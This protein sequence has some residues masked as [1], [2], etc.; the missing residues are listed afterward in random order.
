MDGQTFEEIE[1]VGV[2]KWLDDV[3]DPLILKTDR[4]DAVRRVYLPKEGGKQRPLGIPTIK[5]R[6]VQRAAVIVLEP[7]CEVDLM[8]EP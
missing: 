3:A 5:D 4:P 2:E 7:I 1:A 6:V 8:E